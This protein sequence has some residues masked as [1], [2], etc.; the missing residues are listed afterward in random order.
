MKKIS[1]MMCLLSDKNSKFSETIHLLSDENA[2]LIETVH[3]FHSENNDKD[4]L[5]SELRDK[6]EELENSASKKL[7]GFSSKKV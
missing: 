6:I 5:I 1:D 2:K 3:L 7:F 4:K